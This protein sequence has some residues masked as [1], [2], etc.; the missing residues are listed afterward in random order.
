MRA[1]VVLAMSS[2]V[3]NLSNKT[4]IFHDFQGPTIKFHDFPD[5]ELKFLNSMTFQVFHDCANPI[6]KGQ[7]LCTGQFQNHPSPPPGK[8]QG[9][10]LFWKILVKFP[11]MLPV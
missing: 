2:A 1:Y 4:L 8:P 6:S 5:L 7:R 11:A 3:N 9:I 10:W